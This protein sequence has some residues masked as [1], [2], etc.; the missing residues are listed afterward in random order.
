MRQEVDGGGSDGLKT[1]EEEPYGQLLPAASVFF[2]ACIKIREET[3]GAKELWRKGTES[4]CRKGVEK[5]EKKSIHT[6]H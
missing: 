4:E 3:E 1:T 5:T 6:I 2:C